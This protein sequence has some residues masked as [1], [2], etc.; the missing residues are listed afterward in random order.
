MDIKDI[1]I[2]LLEKC[3]FLLMVFDNHH[4]LSYL[5]DGWS[6]LNITT[7][8]MPTIESL[9]ACC[10]TQSK[11]LLQQ[12]ILALKSQHNELDQFDIELTFATD[13]SI[14]LNCCLHN[15]DQNQH[16]YTVLIFNQ[17]FAQVSSVISNNE[18]QTI[19]EN[20]GE[21]LKV[22]YWQL[23][24][25]SNQ[26]FW[27][28]EIY[29]I[30]G[31][32]PSRYSPQ[33]DTAINFYHA[34]DKPK[35][36]SAVE[37]ALL[38]GQEWSCIKLR[39]V[40]DDQQER[41]VISSGNVSRNKNGEITKLYGIFQDITG[42]EKIAL[43]R[44]FLVTALKETTVGMVIA[45]KNKHVIWVNGSF[46]KMTGYS[47]FE[48]EGKKLGSIL[49]GENTDLKTIAKLKTHL[50]KGLP[51]STRILNYTKSGD[52][53]WNELAISPIYR[54]GKIAYYFA[55]QNDVS[56]EINIEHKLISLNTSLE[57][58]IQARTQELFTLNK[59]LE[60]QAN[61]DPLTGCLNRRTLYRF[62]TDE[63]LK[64]Q[65]ENTYISLLMLDIDHFKAIN[66]NYGHEAGDKGL[67]ELANILHG[68]TRKNDAVF[69][70][71]GEEFLI[72]MPNTN[73]A[74]AKQAAERIKNAVN[75][76]KVYY[77]NKNISFTVS[78]GLLT[79]DGTISLQSSLKYVDDYLYEAKNSGRNKIVD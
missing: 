34:D 6:E 35:I 41:T 60:K 18:L 67:K 57:Q 40:D 53:Y 45:D 47:L 8:N 23:D 62:L 25:N 50:K 69:R 37:N 28:D 43:E 78:I 19:I 5:S 4:Q 33:L 70:L 12:Q 36:A 27:T 61:V 71:G 49:Q 42:S 59:E 17:H 29:T 15:V 55:V 74:E 63:L 44:D 16:H 48:V 26:L 32:S 24:C 79:H 73:K 1:N 65:D 31:V 58:R 10:T 54:D 3:N 64:T 56:K 52:P 46:E 2:A 72:I 75:E 51:I 30:H 22:G 9:Y 11:T 68:L 13:Y 21:V 66:D 14:K 7:K 20:A 77:R 76:H 39:V 38:T